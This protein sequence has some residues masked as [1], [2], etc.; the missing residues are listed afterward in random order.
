MILDELVSCRS[1]QGIIFENAWQFIKEKSPSWTILLSLHLILSACSQMS[2]VPGTVD[3]DQKASISADRTDTQMREETEIARLNDL[4]PDLYQ[5]YRDDPK[6]LV[7]HAIL[8]MKTA[9]GFPTQT[10]REENITIYQ[11]I[12]K[13]CVLDVFAKPEKQQKQIVYVETRDREGYRLSS[14]NC[15]LERQDFS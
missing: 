15:D 9:F 5:A 10:R 8:D 13:S 4:D 3:G 7:G 11:Y 1:R 12:S 14:V 2:S 6:S